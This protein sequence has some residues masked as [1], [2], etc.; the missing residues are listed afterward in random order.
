MNQ[1]FPVPR[2]VAKLLIPFIMLFGFYV[3]FHGDFGPGGGFQAGVI[4]ASAFLLYGMVFGLRAAQRVMRPQWIETMAPLGVL[5]FAGT[6]LF[7]LL[8][9][10]EYLDYDALQHPWHLWPQGQ[11]LGIFLAELGVGLTV[12]SVMIAIYYAF[13]ARGSN[14]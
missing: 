11:H 2:I 7:P 14:S 8:S 1:M 10:G 13:A 6:G 12:S 5:V 3:Q 4:V 9:G